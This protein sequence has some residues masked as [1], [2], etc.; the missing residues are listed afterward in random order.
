MFAPTLAQE[1]ELGATERLA[2]PQASLEPLSIC[3]AEIEAFPEAS[4]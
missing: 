4:S 2:I 1:N 3:A